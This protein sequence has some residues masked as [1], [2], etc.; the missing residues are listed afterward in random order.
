M[1]V[2][3]VNAGLVDGS[4]T[5]NIGLSVV[6]ASFDDDFNGV[7]DQTVS[8]TTTDD[9]TAG[10]TVTASGGSTTVAETGSTDTFTVVLDAQPASDVVISVTSAD[11]G[12]ATVT[13]S[14][15]FTSANWDTAQIP[16]RIGI[17][18]KP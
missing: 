5:T 7:N 12:E 15:I 4:Q 17:R 10:F 13:S 8:A 3:G 11:T 2:I 9:D 1:T 16:L 6:D 18:P 14:L